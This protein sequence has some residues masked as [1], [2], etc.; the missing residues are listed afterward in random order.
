[1]LDLFEV[2]DAANPN[3]VTGRRTS[4][5]RPAQALYMLN[6]PFVTGSSRRAA[7]LLLQQATLEKLDPAACA[8]RAVRMCLGR[9][10]SQSE[11]Q[12]LTPTPANA[13]SVDQWS[14]I[15]HALFSSVDFRY[16]N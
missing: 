13:G 2:F 11:L 14:A 4:S 5:T 16:I 8:D 3:S 15:F 9:P 6:S 7:E 10:A 12:L 1:M